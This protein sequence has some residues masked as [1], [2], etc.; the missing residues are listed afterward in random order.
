MI[1][2]GLKNPET[3][4]N[5]QNDISFLASGLETYRFWS[6]ANSQWLKI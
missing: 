3:S 4:E 2:Q 6:F 5:L 1:G